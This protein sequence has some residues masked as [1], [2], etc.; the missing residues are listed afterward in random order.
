MNW[1]KGMITAPKIYKMRIAFTVAGP[2]DH[3]RI[4]AALRQA[5]LQSALPFERAKVNPNWPRLA[6]GP[7]LG[8]GQYSLGEY[9][10]LYFSSPVKEDEALAALNRAAPQGVHLLRALRVPYALPSVPQL[11]EVMQ[12]GVEGDFSLMQPLAPAQDF[13]AAKHIYVTE[14]APNGMSLQ[15]DL[16]PYILRVRQPQ[17]EKLEL[18]LQRCADKTAKPEYVVAAWL[19]QPVQTQEQFTLKN[20]KF[21]REALYWRDAEQNLHPVQP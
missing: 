19:G 15:Q 16:R 18:L 8:Y 5:V 20:F 7:V 2:W 17:P 10:D 1:K 21:T 13:F 9:A 4:F 3:K 11:A 12:Y 14:Q 6:Y